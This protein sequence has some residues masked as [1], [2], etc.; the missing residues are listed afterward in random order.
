MEEVRTAASNRCGRRG[1]PSGRKPQRTTVAVALLLILCSSWILSSML[2]LAKAN[3][4]TLL[5]YNSKYVVSSTAAVTT[6]STSLQDDTQAS[7]TFSL[8]ASKTVLVIYQ[9]NNVYGAAMPLGMQNA[10]YV[11]GTD[12]ANS[13]DGPYNAVNYCARNTVFWI[14]TLGSGSHTIKGRFA[15]IGTSGTATVSNR[16]LL[17]YILSGD[18]YRYLDD[19]TTATTQS[20]TLIDDPYASFTFTPPSSCK[21]LILYNLANSGASEDGFGKKAAIRVGTTDYSQAEKSPG[22][23]DGPSSVFTLWALQLSASSTTVKGRWAKHPGE[24]KDSTIHRRQLG[25]LMFDDNTLLDT[26]SSDTEVSTSSSS[27]V[28][29]TQ[30]KI[31]RTTTDTRELL[32][33]AMGTKR[34]MV[35][36]TEYGECYGIKVDTNERANSRGS[37]Y[38]SWDADSAGVAYAETLAAGSHTIQGRFSNN[39]GS[40]TAKISSRRFAA[41]WLSVPQVAT[42]ESDYTTP[43]GTYSIGETVYAQ[44][45]GLPA[46]SYDFKYYSDWTGTPYEEGSD[47]NVAESPS[48]KWRSSY[49]LLSGDPPGDWGVRVYDA[50]TITLRCSC[51]FTVQAVPEFPY[52]AAVALVTV[53]TMY[54]AKRRTLNKRGEES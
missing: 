40:T 8:T 18:A 12:Y 1:R 48:G 22:S 14:G 54:L 17:I 10:I 44:A 6:T 46:G 24:A 32:V 27:L 37:G 51:S 16:V 26:V 39:Y 15:R 36:S 11:D 20:T 13:W 41:L 28:N 9:A 45:V 38:G 21:A 4:G 53:F 7:Q 49:T 31:Q 25:V 3:P 34:H 35:E 42:Y 5:T 52:G 29:D 2:P 50:G 23:Y 43:K 30:A 19:S 47:P 33:V